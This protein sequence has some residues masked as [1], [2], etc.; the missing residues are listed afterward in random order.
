MFEL[1]FKKEGLDLRVKIQGS[2]KD[3][4]IA[5]KAFLQYYPEYAEALVI[6]VQE[7]GALEANYHIE[8]LINQLNINN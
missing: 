3:F 4:A 2:K 7:S 1:S 8:Q 5:I 6:A